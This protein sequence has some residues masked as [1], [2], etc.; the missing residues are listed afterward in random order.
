MTEKEIEKIEDLALSL[1]LITVDDVCHYSAMQLIYMVINRLNEVIGSVNG[2]H[3]SIT[4]ILNHWVENGTFD[5]IL[6]QSK[7][8][9]YTEPSRINALSF[10]IKEGRDVDV[11][12]NT[13]CLQNA[14]D[15]CKNDKVLVFPSGDYVFK[16]IDLGEKNNI[17][18]EGVSSSFGTF[19][20][21]NIYTGKI[22]D[23]LTK[24]ICDLQPGE[25]F[26]NHKNCVLV[27]ENISFYNLKKDENG[28]F[29]DEEAKL[30]VLMKHTRT[31]GQ[32]K[33]T[34][35]GKAF[36]LNCG[37]FGFKVCF[38]SEF[39][40]QH[41]ED[42]W[43]TGLRFEDYE[44]LKQSCVMASR[45]RFTRNGVAV[46]QGVDARLIDCSFN[47]NDYAIVFRENSGFSTVEGCRIEWN[48]Y[49]GIYC[50]KAHDVTVSNCEFDCNGW[51]GLHAT[52]NTESNFNGIFRRNGA[53]VESMDDDS[54]QQDYIHN[55][56]IYAHGN[57]NCNFIGSN[58]VVKPI[59]DVGSAPQRPSNCT[60]FT[61]NKNCIVSLNNL[62]G[63]TKKDKTDANKFTN[64]IDCIIEHN[65]LKGRE[66]YIGQV[67]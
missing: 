61:N 37:F 39:T 9:K 6:A 56:H 57:L 48:I 34:E 24:I 8:G 52:N 28:M 26:F 5:D 30:G 67:K 55:V 41:L 35:K 27:L 43:Q 60:N 25:T 20:Q 49:N 7:L 4:D 45:C 23:T 1:N 62:G 29:T 44:Y 59:S 16:P 53:K 51:S 63:C 64:N 42:E 54:Q 36:C 65:M 11:E 14:I 40:F 38:G 58:T 2:I 15:Y 18:I 31:E 47:K 12:E 10:G 19:A 22:K 3:G 32:G 46:N 13:R 50:D 66:E 17:L 21:K 33:N